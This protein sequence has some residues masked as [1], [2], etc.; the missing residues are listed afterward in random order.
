M[1]TSILNILVALVILVLFVFA[2]HY[3]N[4]AEST[5]RYFEFKNFFRSDKLLDDTLFGRL[6]FPTPE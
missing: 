4:D 5:V 6:N 2:N 3:Q 1:T